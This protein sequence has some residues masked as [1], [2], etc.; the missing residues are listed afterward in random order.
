M[1]PQRLTFYHIHLY[2]HPFQFLT[3]FL[4][5]FRPIFGDSRRPKG[6]CFGLYRPCR[7][8][9]W[10]KAFLSCPVCQNQDFFHIIVEKSQNLAFRHKNASCSKRQAKKSLWYRLSLKR[11]ILSL[12]C[13]LIGIKPFILLLAKNERLISFK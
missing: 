11:P 3:A 5:S 12:D 13:F 9:N 4:S 7:H 6:T 1:S 2:F 8:R 10:C